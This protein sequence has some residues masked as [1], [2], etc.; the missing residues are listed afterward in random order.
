MNVS[1]PDALKSFVDEQVA[2]RGHG[3]SSEYV[4]DL[5]RKEQDRQRLRDLLLEGQA[6]YPTAPV[7]DVYFDGLRQRVRQ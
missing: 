3:T 2:A 4:C 5:I 1:L 7:D 6:S